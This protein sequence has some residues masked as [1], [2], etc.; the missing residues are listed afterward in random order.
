MDDLTKLQ[1][2]IPE[3]SI[4]VLII[5]QPGRFQDGLTALISV[6]P[7]VDRI[8][9]ESSI[10]ET[11]RTISEQRPGLALLDADLLGDK[12]VDFLVLLKDHY[13]EPKYFVL[14]SDVQQEQLAKN[15]GVGGVLLKG[16]PAEKLLAKIEALLN[17]DAG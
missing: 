16:F 11:L 17:R 9:H 2:K 13:P 15:T 1:S 8:Y 10:T 12:M 4:S 3:K 6:L 5:A 7:Y 14:A